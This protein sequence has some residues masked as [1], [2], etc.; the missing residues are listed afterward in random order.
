MRS[1]KGAFK[2]RYL[3]WFLLAVP[4]LISTFQYQTGSLYYGEYIHVTGEFSV[5]LL[6]LTMAITPLRMMFPNHRWPVWLMKRRRYFGVATFG[7]AAPHLVAYLVKIG[8]FG[9]IATEALEPGMMTGWI[10]MIVFTILAVTSNNPSVRY[11]KARWKSLHRLVYVA[12]VMTF[13][14]WI[15]VAFNPVAALIHAAVLVLL[16]TFRIWITQN[17]KSH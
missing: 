3:L 12:A 17:S 5:R 2:S 11:L 9:K 4:G 13:L 10:A 1:L 16:E 15:L 7:Y 14:H 6:M 8:A